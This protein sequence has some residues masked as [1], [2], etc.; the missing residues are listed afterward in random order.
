MKPKS[1]KSALYLAFSVFILLTLIS[2]T[3]SWFSFNALK[4]NQLNL[5]K[6][7][8]PALIKTQEM[9]VISSQL[10]TLT[11]KLLTVKTQSE[12]TTQWDKLQEQSSQL[13]RVLKGYKDINNNQVV[14][15]IDDLALQLKQNLKF[16]YDNIL[17]SLNIQQVIFEA[18][19]RLEWLK[20]DTV[21][22][23]TPLINDVSFNLDQVLKS[24][25]IASGDK[26][27]T[28]IEKFT[29]FSS[30][31]NQLNLINGIVTQ[32]IDST[33]LNSLMTSQLYTSQ[34]IEQLKK[35]S[36]KLQTSATTIALIQS[37]NDYFSLISGDENV[38]SKSQIKLELFKRSVELVEVNQQLL[39]T[40]NERIKDNA[41]LDEQTALDKSLNIFKQIKQS[42]FILLI[43]FAVSLFIAILIGWLYVKKSLVYRILHLNDNMQFIAQGL[44]DKPIDTDGHDEIANM[45]TSLATFRDTLIETQKEL[46]QAGK[47]AALGQ[48][49]AGVAHELN[50]PLAAIRNY[51]HNSKV[52][53]ERGEASQ[54]NSALEQIDTL[55][56]HMAEIITQF[57][58]FSRKPSANIK[59]ILLSEAISNVLTI[60]ENSIEKDAIQLTLPKLIGDVKVNAEL[61]RLEQVLLNLITN[62]ID[63]LEHSEL[64]K[65]ILSCELD[66][67][68]HMLYLSICDSG[69]GIPEANRAQIFE[70]FYSTK[71]SKGLGLGLSISYNIMKDF[72][73]SLECAFSGS[74]GTT[75][76]L[77]LELSTTP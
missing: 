74:M 34:L 64:K 56:E 30:I 20:N 33:D 61:I 40:I 46:V 67:D 4:D 15:D 28:Q 25:R 55:T 37:M 16:I 26:L 7:D 35:D 18:K 77:S 23:I 9:V 22:E 52:L 39:S 44:M 10:S 76:V 2:V 36:T 51:T 63:S 27:N 50:Q 53:I 70:P 41:A 29:L 58:Q 43:I 73:G 17:L 54:A 57:K 1:I 14:L 65:I 8:I 66:H 5:V 45:A 31:L 21:D 6:S 72:N 3:T 75:F 11:N 24:E 62:A 47:L 49:S 13:N 38:Y 59:P 69:C 42:Q 32:T 71:K 68:N 48:L 19:I 12:L 60:L